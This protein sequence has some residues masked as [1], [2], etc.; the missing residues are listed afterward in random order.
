MPPTQKLPVHL[1][2]APELRSVLVCFLYQVDVDTK[3]KVRDSLYPKLEELAP[4][5]TCSDASHMLLRGSTTFQENEV[6]WATSS[7]FF[8]SI[9]KTTG[10]NKKK[11][12][13]KEQRVSEFKDLSL[14]LPFLEGPSGSKTHGRTNLIFPILPWSKS[15]NYLKNACYTSKYPGTSHEYY[16]QQVVGRNSQHLLTTVLQ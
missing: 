12:T 4:D 15:N 9:P 3:N 2:N 10:R 5:S 14:L 11:R 1:K 16:L 6:C 7:V 13:R 8:L